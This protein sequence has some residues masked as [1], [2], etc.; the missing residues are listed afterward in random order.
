MFTIVTVDDEKT[1]KKGLRKIIELH[2][3]ECEVIGEAEDGLE[4]LELVK[5]LNPHVVITDITMPVMN[6]IEL[7]SRI[8][9]WNASTELIVLSGYNEFEYAQKALRYGVRDFLL[10]P[11]NPETVVSLVN[12][13]RDAHVR[14]TAELERQR[15]SLWA[16]AE[17]VE[18]LAE[19]LWHMNEAG[20]AASLDAIARQ[21]AEYRLPEELQAKVYGDLAGCLYRKI[22]ERGLEFGESE[23][24]GCGTLAQFESC[25]ARV[26]D[27]ILSSRNWGQRTAVSQ[28]LQY[29]HE[30]YP[31]SEL[32]LDKVTSLVQLSPAYFYKLFKDETGHSFKSY[33][34][35]LR[36]CKAREMLASRQFKTTYEIAER[37]GYPDYPHFVKVFRKYVGLSPSEFRRNMGLS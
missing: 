30:H 2:C 27:K 26:S 29:I 3:P 23:P 10:K 25:V 16:C 18:K 22:R 28:A 7:I 35:E 34:I 13:I 11:M 14:R 31:D 37:I 24:V 6:G 8:R 5:R 12:G 17:I 4:A 15:N 20:S 21:M 19:Q 36:M 1:V 9:A 32:T 33:L